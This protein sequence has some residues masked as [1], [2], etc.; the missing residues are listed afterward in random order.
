MT[1][2]LLS[3]FLAVTVF[4]ALLQQTSKV[5]ADSSEPITFNS[6]VTLYSPINKT[7]SSKFLTLNLTSWVGIGVTCSMTYNIDNQH[8][9]NIPL[10][11]QH[12]TELHMLNKVTANVTLPEL[13]QGIHNGTLEVVCSIQNSHKKISQLP[14]VPKSSNYT[15]NTAT[16]TDT[17]QFSIQTTEQQIPE[18]SPQTLL[19]LTILA[20]TIILVTKNHKK[21]KP[22]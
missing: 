2:N 14:V 7:Y 4:V 22:S 11:S 13:T 17:M 8:R 12:P 19:I 5:Y 3:L 16:W 20:P 6:R 21:N 1:K 15:F 18:F 9:G 10:V